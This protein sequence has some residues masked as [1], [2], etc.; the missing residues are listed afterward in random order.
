MLVVEH[1]VMRVLAT[2]ELEKKGKQ[3]LVRDKKGFPAIG[4]LVCALS[5][6]V[7]M[8]H[9]RRGGNVTTELAYGV[10]RSASEHIPEICNDLVSDILSGRALVF[11]WNVASKIPGFRL[12]LLGVVEVQLFWHF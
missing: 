8:V 9:F 10:Y 11:T 7:T 5:L 4:A 3:F 2:E 6:G 1:G 12:S